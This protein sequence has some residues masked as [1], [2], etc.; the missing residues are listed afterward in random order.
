[1]FS[2]ESQNF[3][4]IYIYRRSKSTRYFEYPAKENLAI[5]KMRKPVLCRQYFFQLEYPSSERR[6]GR[7]SVFGMKSRPGMTGLTVLV[8]VSDLFFIIFPAAHCVGS[9]WSEKYTTQ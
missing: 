4:R 7:I 1:V 5:I 6:S 9:K 8:L 3:A 2:Y